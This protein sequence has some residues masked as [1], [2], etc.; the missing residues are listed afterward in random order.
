MLI[1][2]KEKLQKLFL[3]TK[4]YIFKINWKFLLQIALVFAAFLKTYFESYWVVLNVLK[5]FG[6]REIVKKERMKR[7]RALG[8]ELYK[9][10]EIER[11]EALSLVNYENGLTFFNFKGI[12][13]REDQ[14]GID[15]LHWGLIPFWVKD[16]RAAAE[17][18]F[19]TFNARAETLL[20]KPAFRTA[21]RSK[22][23][24]VLVRGFYEWQHRGKDKIPYFIYLKDQQPL[25]MAG[26]YDDWTDRETG[27][28]LQ[29]CTV[30]TTD[31]NP[32]ME[33]IHNSKKRMPAILSRDSE[34][35]WIDP[36][37]PAEQAMKCLQPLDESK[38]NAH[39]I[40]KLISKRGVEKNVPE[41]V[42]PYAY[43]SD[44]LL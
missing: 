30:I 32:I 35:A 5:Q 2:I 13:G 33:K 43:D 39:T 14:E 6:R 34:N 38:M 20:S 17:I 10:R 40:S 11:R 3:R 7:I 4:Q 15:L 12:R 25:A 22:R 36:D 8:N 27:E 23:C 19:K 18:R 9:Q 42:A 37:L 16:S 29:S 41:L 24:L 28:W 44:R 31:A 1:T 26:I 21:A